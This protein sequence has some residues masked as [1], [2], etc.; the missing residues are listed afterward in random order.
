ML[1]Y[2]WAHSGCLSGLLLLRLCLNE[3]DRSK[4]KQ[5]KKASSVFAFPPKVSREHFSMS[6]YYSSDIEATAFVDL[7]LDLN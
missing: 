2:K 5:S 6:C 1:D 7:H 3:L 4:S